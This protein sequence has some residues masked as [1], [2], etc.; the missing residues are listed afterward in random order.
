MNLGEIAEV[1]KHTESAAILTHMRPDGDTLGSGMALCRALSFLGKR[2]E[3]LNEG[4]LPDR[5]D[6]LPCMKEVKTSLSFAPA[7]YICVDVSNPS[8]LGLLESVYRAG[9][10]RRAVTVNIDHHVANTRFAQYNFVRERASNCENIAELLRLLN[11]TPDKACADALM[12]G[13]ATDSGSFSHG[14]VNGDTFRE[15]AFAADCGGD[16]SAAVY[17]AMKKQTKGRAGLYAETVSMLRFFLDDRLAVAFV[18]L[19]SLEKYGVPSHATEGIV[20]FALTIDRVETSVCLL[21]VKKG[22]YKASFR[23][24]GTV[25]VNEVAGVFGGGGHVLAAGCTFFGD[26]EEA[27]DKLRYAVEQRLA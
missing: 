12:L 14:D 10:K 4:P 17:H 9:E 6:Y 13:M 25:N 7:A 27:I 18:P 11:V 20:D 5:F 21:E 3:V 15:A 8:R 26:L 1:L 22:Q 24:K 19:S 23:S 2:C 16:V